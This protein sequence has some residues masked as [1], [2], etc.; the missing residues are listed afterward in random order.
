MLNITNFIP[1][2]YIM[3]KGHKLQTFTDVPEFAI[4][5]ENKSFLFERGYIPLAYAHR[6]DKISTLFYNTPYLAD[7]LMYLNGISDPFEE[8]DARD[9][10]L[11]PRII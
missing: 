5:I 4:L 7:Y 3:Y 9:E 8:M 10:I 6:P 1:S 11:L 2:R